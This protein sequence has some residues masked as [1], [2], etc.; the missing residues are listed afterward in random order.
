MANK[1]L[2]IPDMHGHYNTLKGLLLEAGTIDHQ[3]NRVEGWRVI[4]LG[5]LANCVAQGAHDDIRCLRK[6][7][8]WIDEML[9][10]N[11]EYPY[12][13]GK[14][15]RF[16]FGGFFDYPEVE[17]ELRR[18]EK[19]GMLVPAALV[20]DVLVTHAGF[21][22]SEGIE[23]AQ[24]G[25]DYLTEKWREDK[26]HPIFSQVG[27]SRGGSAGFGGVLWSDW[28]ERKAHEFNQIMGHTPQ[29]KGVQR[30]DY[31]STGKWSM[32]IDCGAKSGKGATGVVFDED[33]EM[34][35]VETT[36]SG[37]HPF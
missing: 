2:I 4:Q 25:F 14:H 8:D 10:G 35:F 6:V 20:G 31:E 7:G 37:N 33:G 29:S 28:M 30:R 22:P 3:G 19:Q 17:F 1:T 27:I 11:H 5:D 26:T 18:I 23:S 12:F 9:P 24:D 16:A 34:S 21:V 32:C 13:V 15:S 36:M